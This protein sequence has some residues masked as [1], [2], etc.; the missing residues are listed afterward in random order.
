MY[1]ELTS[2]PTEDIF[3]Q[4]FKFY[5]SNKIK[6]L[7]SIL[8]VDKTSDEIIN[9]TYEDIKEDPR[10]EILGLTACKEWQCFCFKSHPGLLFIRNPFTNS[11]QRYWVRRCLQEYP[12]NPNKLNIDVDMNIQDWWSMCYKDG[13]CNRKLLKK[14]RWTTLGYHHNWDTKVKCVH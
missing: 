6:P 4:K 13:P 1:E 11:G 2:Y 10:T 7:N 3:M 14:L 9:V 12:K 5:K 8:C